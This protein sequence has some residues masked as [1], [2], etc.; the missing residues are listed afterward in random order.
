MLTCSVN[1]SLGLRHNLLTIPP[2]AR[3]AYYI[4][5]VLSVLYLTRP[6]L[7][8]SMSTTFVE[9]NEQYAASFDKGSLPMPPS[10]HLLVVTCMDARINP[11]ASLGIELGESHIVRN[12]GGRVKDAIRSIVVSQRLLGT[13]E[14]AVFHHTD[15][16]MTT[17]E[18]PQLREIVK[19]DDAS[20]AVAELVDDFDF[21][22]FSNLELSVR[23]DV[24]YLKKNP[25]LLKE[26]KISGWIYHTETGKISR[27]V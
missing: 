7:S 10:K 6:S 2:P 4:M 15:C 18:T 11:A 1:Y 8:T 21:L 17:F 3:G 5:R 26:T 12:A 16:G 13:R 20:P 25:L 22:E 23:E 19:K 24:E 14:I 9:R 27:V